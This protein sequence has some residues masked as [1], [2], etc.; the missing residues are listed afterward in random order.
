MKWHMF[1]IQQISLAAFIYELHNFLYSLHGLRNKRPFHS[2]SL[3]YMRTML[4]IAFLTVL[5][6]LSFVLVDAQQ[7]HT[8]SG[9]IKDSETGET[10]I[11]SNIF[12]ENDA[13][14]GTVTNTYG[15]YS[16]TMPSGTYRIVFSYLGYQTQVIEIYLVENTTLNVDM[17]QGI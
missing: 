10:L 16:M 7:N 13:T 4:R 8:I 2:F 6:A 17:D 11:G 9:Y 12:L 14:R 1:S 3:D 15:F 5:S